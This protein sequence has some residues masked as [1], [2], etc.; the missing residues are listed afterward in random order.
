MLA[1]VFTWS[2]NFVPSS[3]QQLLLCGNVTCLSQTLQR[4]ELVAGSTLAGEVGP[5]CDV[6]RDSDVGDD[7][8]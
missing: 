8:G 2:V 6:G 3:W 7:V 5:G 1:E 4:M